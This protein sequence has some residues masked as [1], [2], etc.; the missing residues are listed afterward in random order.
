MPRE[1]ILK[2]VKHVVLFTL[3]VE[4][5]GVILLTIHWAGE[6]PF[7]RSLY[8]GVFHSISAFCN[9]GF[10]LFSDSFTRYGGSW[11]L[12]FTICALIVVGGIGFPVLHD[13]Y[14]QFRHRKG[15]RGRLNVQTKMVLV[16]T[17][18]LI[19][20]GALVFAVLE[21]EAIG[22]RQSTAERVLT[23]VFQSI[24]CRTAG[25]NTV[26]I[27]ALGDATLFLMIFL[28]FVGA[29]PGSTGGGVKTTTLAVISAFTL[30]RLKRSRRVNMFK[31]TIP[32]ETVVRSASLIL[33]AITVIGIV[34]FL[35]LLSSP[36]SNLGATGF[37]R[38]FL[39]YLFETVSAFGTVGISMGATASLTAWG[40]I[41]IVVMMIIGRVGVLTFSYVIVGS[42]P[43]KGIEYAEEGV[44]IG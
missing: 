21:R 26:D 42:V 29:S 22:S 37:H 41:W 38:P 40:K 18:V 6:Y 3:F 5:G 16:T 1:D 13:L 15:K 27:G 30:N 24:A 23:P 19:A 31:K 25:F 9:A 34:L 39:A 32:D 36:A 4:L 8:L 20:G 11:L 28:M 12:N 33:I 35:I 14:L 44:M 10:S 7:A 2:M 17:A 43:R